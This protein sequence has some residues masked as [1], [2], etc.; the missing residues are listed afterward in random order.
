MSQF[1]QS[2]GVEEAEEVEEEEASVLEK[3]AKDKANYEETKLPKWLYKYLVYRFNL[4]DRTGK[5]NSHSIHI[6]RIINKT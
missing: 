1:L 3:F 4:L 6:S 2:Q 5:I